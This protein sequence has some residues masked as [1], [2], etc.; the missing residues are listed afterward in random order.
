MTSYLDITISVTTFTNHF[1]GWRD[2]TFRQKRQCLG[3]FD[4]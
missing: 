4:G 3:W 1:C 2:D